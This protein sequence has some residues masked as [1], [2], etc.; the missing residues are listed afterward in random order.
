MKEEN[1]QNESERLGIGS[2]IGIFLLI[3]ALIAAVY[4]IGS[5]II[6]LFSGGFSNTSGLSTNSTV[7]YEAGAY[8]AE[9]Y[10][11]ED[12]IEDA[13]VYETLKS[14]ELSCESIGVADKVIVVV[15]C[16]TNHADLI[17]YYGSSTIYYAFQKSADKKSYWHYASSDRD[18]AIDKVR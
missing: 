16:T 14:S 13:F 18:V 4:N 15:K 10:A 9:D 6:S 17:D 8:L 12:I 11:V 3:F 7:M 1:T 2:I 5:F